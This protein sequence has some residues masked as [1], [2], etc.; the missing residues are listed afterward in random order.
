M[1]HLR[2]EARR[3]E[4]VVVAVEFHIGAARRFGIFAGVAAFHGADRVSGARNRALGYLGGVRIADRFVFHGAQPEALV[5]VIGRLLEAPVVPHQHL[6]LLV[7]EEQLAVVGAFEA[8]VD[9]LADTH[10]IKAGAIEEGGVG[11]HENLRWPQH[12]R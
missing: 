1:R 9:Q 8:A 11:V 2:V 3:F 6:G 4:R 5:G 12:L 10:A 7:F